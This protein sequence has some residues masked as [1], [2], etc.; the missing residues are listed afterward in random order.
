MGDQLFMNASILSCNSAV[1]CSILY[2]SSIGLLWGAV[3]SASKMLLPY[4]LL[5]EGLSEV[6]F[7]YFL[8]G[9]QAISLK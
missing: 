9:Y 3:A 5:E 6:L 2:M 7:G 4:L 8:Q 1:K